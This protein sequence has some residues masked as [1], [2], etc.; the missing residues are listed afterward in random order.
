VGNETT[1]AVAWGLVCGA[2]AIFLIPVL[3]F[4]INLLLTSKTIEPILDI[5]ENMTLAEFNQKISDGA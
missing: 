4:E 3:Y 1:S 2:I 5:V